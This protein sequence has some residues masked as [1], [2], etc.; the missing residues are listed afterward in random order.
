M[1]KIS[2]IALGVALAFGVT[3]GAMTAAPALAQKDKEQAQ[4]LPKP[5]KAV[6]V[7][8]SDAQ[9]LYQANDFAGALAKAREAQAVSK[10]KEDTYLTASVMRAA[11]AQL[12][13][14]PT[15]KQTSEAMLASGLMSPEDQAKTLRVLAQVAARD[16][17]NAGAIARYQ[18][19]TQLEPNN[20]INYFNI[21]ALAYQSKQWPT[22]LTNVHKAIELSQAAGTKPPADWYALQLQAAYD[23]NVTDQVIPAAVTY[24]SAYPTAENWSDAIDILRRSARFDDNGELDIY[25]LAMAAGAMK[26][27]G[28]YLDYADTALRRG[29]PSET[30]YVLDQGIAKG[31]LTASKP[32]VKE[33]QGS[34][35]TARVNADKASLTAEEARVRKGGDGKSAAALA[36]GYLSHQD[37]AKAAE[38]YQLALQRGGAGVD[39]ALVNTRLGIALAKAGR[40]AEAQAAFKAVTGPRQALAQYWLAWLGQQA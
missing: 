29:L 31:M 5:S 12:N 4:K 26:G 24:V 1:K 30:K 34:A 17:D 21:A 15:I 37:W 18:Q 39:A 35:T 38:F 22:V 9:K 2:Q 7:I 11:A 8:L 27:E 25:R 28:A 10:T 32:Q 13:D 3:A 19:L 40:K 23:G 20:A 14:Y 6:A 33:L 16:K 36:D